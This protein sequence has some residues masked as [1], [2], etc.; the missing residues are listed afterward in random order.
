M[1][2]AELNAF[3]YNYAKN[4]LTRGAVILSGPP[5]SGRSHYVRYDL[6]PYL[7]NS[8]ETLTCIAI[9][10]DGIKSVTELSKTIFL[11][12]RTRLLRRKSEKTAAGTI[13]AKTVL[14]SLAKHYDVVID[15]EE[16]DFDNLYS[17]IDLANK[18]IV[19]EDIHRTEIPLE[20]LFSYVSSLTR[21]DG[22]KVLL[23]V[24]DAENAPDADGMAEKMDEVASDIL[25]YEPDM[26]FIV[27]CVLEEYQSPVLNGFLGNADIRE[28]VQSFEKHGSF[29]IRTLFF[30]CQ[31]S[32]D[33]Y[34]MMDVENTQYDPAFLKAVFL[35]I[36]EYSLR[37]KS[38]K[39]L[40]WEDEDHLSFRLGSERYPLFRFCYHYINEQVYEPVLVSKAQALFQ[41]FRTYDSRC[42][43][44]DPDLATMYAWYCQRESDLLAAVEGITAK[45]EKSDAFPLREY[46]R[47][48][49]CL[50]DV[51]AVLHC[52]ITAAEERMISNLRGK[53]RKINS[54]YITR[55]LVADQDN[56]EMTAACALLRKRMLNALKKVD[57]E[58]YG[59]S[60][61]PSEIAAFSGFIQKNI[62]AIL[63]FGTFARA[64]DNRRIQDM[65]RECT[66]KELYDFRTAYISVYHTPHCSAF[67]S[68]D[69]EALAELSGFVREL[70]ASGD[71]DRIQRKN[72]QDFIRDL[73][74]IALD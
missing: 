2:R 36:L 48:A 47:I 23:I 46:G 8:K 37:L 5:E 21:Q 61:R 68:Q 45:L 29:C 62:D 14:K 65:L 7:K 41:E 3:I 38:D 51:E 15:T 20:Q 60:Y 70:T 39:S 24:D 33:L 17:N 58:F 1:K 44:V 56:P 18:L 22:V 31:K 16:A 67:L 4:D 43:A 32:A 26:P 49:R 9:S 71:F 42:A 28:I 59:F 13:M 72:L 52:D 50:L 53:G 55:W 12:N 73:D 74:A 35:G 10:L 19:F 27:R 57:V 25:K 69:K 40:A 54:D 64:L 6:A 30:A 11:E 34:R 63:E 66:A